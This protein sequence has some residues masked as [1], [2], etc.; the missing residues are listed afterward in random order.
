MTEQKH[1]PEP[2]APFEQLTG[3]QK[4][5]NCTTNEYECA[6]ISIPDYG[7]ARECVNAI[8][9]IPDPA[10]FIEA[11]REV[12]K[13][14]EVISSILEGQARKHSTPRLGDWHWPQIAKIFKQKSDRLYRA[15]GESK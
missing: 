12:L 2:W 7:R 6:S 9:G 4:V 15:I 13:Y 11:T 10:E 8:Q 3:L 5:Y 1:T 14:F